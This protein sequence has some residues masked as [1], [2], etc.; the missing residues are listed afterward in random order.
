M[1]HPIGRAWVAN[2]PLFDGPSSPWR[3]YEVFTAVRRF[4]MRS[5]SMV[6]AMEATRDSAR[7][8]ARAIARFIATAVDR[9]V[10]RAIER[11]KVTVAGL[12]A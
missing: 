1:V 4:V 2:L 11:E 12:L 6:V 5:V 8:A 3:R 10:E 9:S 7:E